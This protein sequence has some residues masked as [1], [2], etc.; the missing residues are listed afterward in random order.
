MQVSAGGP[1]VLARTGV[2]AG[3]PL[4]DERGQDRHQASS[5]DR[6]TV[7]IVDSDG[8]TVATI[9]PTV[10]VGAHSPQ[11]FVW[12]GRT[13]AGAL[14]PDGVYYPWVQL[15][16][17]AGRSVHEQDHA[18]HEA[19]GG[20]LAPRRAQ[21]RPLCRAR[22]LG[23][24]PIR[25]SER[26]TR[27]STSAA[28]RSSSAA[29]PGRSDKI[30]W[31]GTARAAGRFPRAGTSSRSA[32]RTSPATR[33]PPAE[34]KHVTVVLRYIELTPERITVRSGRRFTV[35]VET[36]ARRYTWRL[37]QQARRAAREGPAAARADHARARTG[38]SWP[39]TGTPPPPSCGCARSDRAR[40]R[41]PGRSPAS[42]SRSCCSRGRAGTGSPDSAT[43]ES[44]PSCSRSSLAPSNAAELGAAVGGVIV[45]GPLLVWLFRREPWLVAFA[46]LAFV[47]FRIGFLG[48]S[49]LV[50]LYAVALG[51]AGL[52]LWQLVEGTSGRA[53]SA[54]L[55]WPLALYLVWSGLSVGV[56]RRRAHGGDRPPRLLRPV[57]DHRGLDRAPAVAHVARP[58]PLRGAR[59]DGARLRR[60][61][62][63]P[64]RD[65]RPSSRTRS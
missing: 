21:A 26:R 38:S 43:P 9:A 62:L 28:G 58:D 22:P 14:A 29:R 48:H 1:A 4:P 11:H 36:A 10:L 56:E 12:D 17:R 59:G 64:V 46:T 34:R 39:R 45:F 44:A 52:L 60:R 13:D 31:A 7:T 57:H 32:R 25:L 35:H 2:L 16:T 51:A 33:R 65:A 23:R 42:G 19:A 49:L 27:S 6:V 8:N 5:P 20:A 3:L 63:L 15:A 55:A 24:D 61:R 53:S 54:S 41:S 47:P 37:G 30:K 40:A 18:R 50:P